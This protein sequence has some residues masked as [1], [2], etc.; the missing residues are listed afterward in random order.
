MT[1][2]RE[3]KKRTQALNPKEPTPSKFKTGHSYPGHLEVAW[4]MTNER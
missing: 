3:K 2:L 1:L 4:R